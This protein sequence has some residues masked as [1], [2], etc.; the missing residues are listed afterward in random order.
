MAYSP[1]VKI[2]LA[3][4]LSISSIT[5]YASELQKVSVERAEQLLFY[6]EKKATA[7]V[8]SINHAQVPAQIAGQV[9]EITVQQG[10]KVAKG[11]VLVKLDC[12]DNDF[13]LSQANYREVSSAA[14]LQQAK[15]SLTRTHKLKASKHVGEAELDTSELDVIIAKQK[16]LQAKSEQKESLLAVQRCQI[17]APFAGVVTERFVNEGDY[18]NKG[19]ALVK[20]LQRNNL[21]IAAQIPVEQM[22]NFTQGINYYFDSHGKSYPVKIKNIVDYIEIN[23]RSQ[24]V[25]FTV[26]T[27]K[28][29]AGMS[30]MIR[31]Q[32]KSSYLPSPSAY[33]A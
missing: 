8:Q 16:L 6:P 14:K 13:K 9:N 26:S 24:I 32:A 7:I 27:D 30:G 29:I 3:A 21:E 17:V 1:L 10:T 28:I 5:G 4:S 31:W 15:R 20:V 12:Q 22:N 33:P 18:V 23:S 11:Q 2:T 19:Q 25:T